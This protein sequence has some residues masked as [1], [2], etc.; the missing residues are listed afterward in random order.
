[1]TRLGA[2]VARLRHLLACKLSPTFRESAAMSLELASMKAD[3][4]S[5]RAVRDIATERL[6]ASERQL[7]TAN[8]TARNALEKAKELQI[9]YED[10]MRREAAASADHI[11]TLK[12]VANQLLIA[13]RSIPMFDGFGPTKP[14]PTEEQQPPFSG[15]L[16][17]RQV[18]NLANSEF[19]KEFQKSQNRPIDDTIP[20]PAD[21]AAT[22]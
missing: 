6:I 14:V 10:A 2:K 22:A 11:G 13:S 21:A 19:M 9:K 5:A 4:Y 8:A 17:A 15:R 12:T 16:R 18:V 7:E 1:M 3:L 20:T